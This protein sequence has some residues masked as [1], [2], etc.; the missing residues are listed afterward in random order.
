MH[1]LFCHIYP[2]KH[3]QLSKAIGMNDEC[4]RGWHRSPPGS[5]QPGSIRVSVLIQAQILRSCHSSAMEEPTKL[6]HDSLQRQSMIEP[7]RPSSQLK[8]RNLAPKEVT[9]TILR[10]LRRSIG[11]GVYKGE[12][13][14]FWVQGPQSC[15]DAAHHLAL[16]CLGLR[17]TQGSSNQRFWGSLGSLAPYLLGIIITPGSL[18]PRISMGSGSVP[19]TGSGFQVTEVALKRGVEGFKLRGDAGEEIFPNAAFMMFMLHSPKGAVFLVRPMNLDPCA[20][21]QS[22]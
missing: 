5:S 8:P 22:K 11:T 7:R 21:S 3:K 2:A 17:Q 10:V 20:R 4:S 12:D 18:A 6:M 1:V 16:L 13:A 15:H 19:L 14:N 9:K